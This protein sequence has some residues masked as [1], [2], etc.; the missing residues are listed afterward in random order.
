[1]ETKNKKL[2]FNEIEQLHRV[3]SD[4]SNQS[5][6]VKIVDCNFYIIFSNFF[7]A[8]SAIELSNLVYYNVGFS[9]PVFCYIYENI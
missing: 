9:I 8:R 1:M 7:G 5:V 2:T 3:V 4:F 6:M